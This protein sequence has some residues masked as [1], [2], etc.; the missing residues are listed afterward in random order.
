MPGIVVN[1]T[2]T[3]SIVRG[4]GWPFSCRKEV[5]AVFLRWLLLETKAGELLLAFLER[6]AGLAVVQSDWLG[7]QL[8][9]A[10]IADSR[11]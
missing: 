10:P 11:G 8:S 7:D 3:R 4:I 6:K 2:A 9:G 5:M 1:Q